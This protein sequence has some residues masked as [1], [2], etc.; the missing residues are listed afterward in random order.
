LSL[1]LDI[2]VGQTRIRLIR[3]CVQVFIYITI[4]IYMYI[5]M[6]IYTYIYIYVYMYIYI[7]NIY[8]Y[9]YIHTQTPGDGHI[10][11]VRVQYD[12]TEI[13][14][15]QILDIFFD[16]DISAFGNGLGQYQVRAFIFSWV[17]CFGYLLLGCSVISVS[18]II[19]MLTL[20]LMPLAGLYF[21]VGVDF[22]T[23]SF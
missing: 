20:L 3:Q 12:D 19:F 4:C 5:Y 17:E 9:I 1:R 16:R 22:V 8:I 18:F 6:Y 23:L 13:S 7:N 15:E 2:V 14:Y 11:A 10:E 21:C